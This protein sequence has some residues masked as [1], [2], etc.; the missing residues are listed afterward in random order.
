MNIAKTFHFSHLPPEEKSKRLGFLR[1]N[2][3]A[4]LG[5]VLWGS[6]YTS[7]GQYGAVITGF[8]YITFVCLGFLYLY[9]K[10]NYQVFRVLGLLALLLNPIASQLS[11]GGFVQGSAVILAASLAPICALMVYNLK[12]SRIFFYAYCVVVLMTGLIEAFLLGE[13]KKPIPE[14]TSLMFFVSNSITIPAIFY[15]VMEYIFK[16]QNKFKKVIEEKNTELLDKQN[17][18]TAYNEE[19]QQQKEEL[20]ATLEVVQEKNTIIRVKNENIT[21]SINYAST[22]QTAMLPVESKVSD[23]FKGNFFAFSKPRDI[24]SGDLYWCEKIENTI[25][26]A[27]ADCTG[28]GVPGALMSMM[29]ISELNNIVFQKK[30]HSPDLI[31]ENLHEHIYKMLKQE[32]QENSDGMDIS[33]LVIHQD[34]KIATFAGAMNPLYCIQENELRVIKGDKKPIGGYQHGKARNYS[35][36]QINIDKATTFYMCSD[37]YQDQFGGVGN[38]KFGIRRLKELFL[39][40]H[41]HSFQIQKQNLEMTFKEWL[42]K[43]YEKQIDDVLIVGFL[44]E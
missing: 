32:N 31:L 22:I 4:A 17:E 8:G 38:G 3:Y 25:F 18:I 1:V 14:S 16:Q 40:Q 20:S 6:T 11:L 29:G 24:V 26:I 21:A 23:Y 37:G 42:E 13:V 5:G 9:L 2:L 35:K 43:G 19:L 7:F 28:H 33:L 30:I 41:I 36:R 27:V 12:A 44:S 39:T 10:G 34:P 15:F